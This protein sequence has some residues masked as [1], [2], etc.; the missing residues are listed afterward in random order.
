M[1]QATAKAKAV[2]KPTQ[3]AKNAKV[4]DVVHIKGAQVSHLS[5]LRRWFGSNA[6]IHWFTGTMEDIVYL[7]VGKTKTTMYEVRYELPDGT[8]KLLRKKN[9]HHHPGAWVHPN[10]PPSVPILGAGHT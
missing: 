5:Q 2:K 4:G 1:S 9:I 7:T 6:E 8:N 3:Y 10:P